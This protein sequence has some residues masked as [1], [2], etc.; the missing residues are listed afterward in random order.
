M[1]LYRYSNYYY[2]VVVVDWIDRGENTMKTRTTVCSSKCDAYYVDN[3]NGTQTVRQIYD[4]YND[5]WTGGLTP[6][7]RPSASFYFDI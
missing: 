5:H 1:S 6:K 2:S 7:K 4:S 3:T